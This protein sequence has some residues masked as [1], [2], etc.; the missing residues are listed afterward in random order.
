MA[1]KQVEDRWVGGVLDGDGVT[2]PQMG[3]EDAFQAVE[4]PRW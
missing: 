3:V 2:R 1:R 4:R